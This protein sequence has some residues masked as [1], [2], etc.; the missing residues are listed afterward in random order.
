MKSIATILMAAGLLLAAAAAATQKASA[1]PKAK[2]N[3]IDIDYVEPKLAE[4]QAVY[5]LVKEQQGLEKIRD[6]LSPLRLPHRLLLQTRDCEG[7]SNAFSNEDS[8]IVCYEY[9]NDIWKSAPE[10]TTP[11]GV[12]PID[13]LIGPLVDV[14]LHEA[15]H[16][17]FDLLGIPFLGREED[18]ADQFS[19]YLLLQMSSDCARRLILAVAYLG[20]AQAQRELAHPVQLS[21]FADVHELPAQRYFNVLCMAYGEDPKVFG[22]AVE[23]WHLPKDRAKNCR[24][25]YRRFQYAFNALI[26]PYVD[27]ALVEKVKAKGLLVA[28]FYADL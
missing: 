3:S 24:Y 23:R 1:A 12:A 5:K 27:E 15:G 19:A 13:A 9:L 17:V 16:A 11:A 18:A 10:T 26:E 20:S 22:D 14:F 21:Q 28:L 2:A 6:L 8:V 4:N 7:V 25:E